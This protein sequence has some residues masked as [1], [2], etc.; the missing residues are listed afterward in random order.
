M[1]I[2]NN[3]L[4]NNMMN[5]ISTNLGRMQK[6]QNQ[7]ASGK[8][9][10]V[11]SDDPI[12]AA[13][14][15]KYRTD[16]SELGQFSR[17]LNDATSW[18]DM[19]ES[20]LGNI[21]DV[22]QR[23]RELAVQA[24]NGTNNADDTQKIAKEVDQLRTQAIHLAN[25]TYAGRYIFSGYKTDKKLINDDGTFATSVANTEAIRYEI[26]IGDS[27]DINVPGGD[28]FNNGTDAA[29]DTFSSLSG[30]NPI[31]FPVTI[32][33]G[34]NDSLGINVD[35]EAVTATIPA[36]NYSDLASLANVVQTAVNVGTLTSAD[37]NVSVVGNSL[38]FR[39]GSAGA[40]S[41]ISIVATS[42]AA[43]TLGVDAITSTPSQTGQKGKLMQD[44]DSLLTAMNTGDNATISKLIGD[45]DD[46]MNNMLRIRADVGA[47]QNRLELTGNRLENDNLNFTKLMSDN[48]DVD[49]SE[50]IMNLQNEENVYKASLAGGAKII[51]PS[52]VDFLR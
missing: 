25:S 17:N 30:N 10:Q 35:G 5:N 20:T 6:Y 39:S 19:T 12:V 2:T 7:L 45:L 1:R 33:T 15:L 29:G 42:N 3:M 27:I 9:I 46:D 23:T 8:K 44:F 48:E 28:M 11:P 40:N 43:V 47:R 38:S 21:G 18:M 22:L 24:S 26:G 4:V 31:T 32:T 49:M 16:V 41:S 50:T 34:T 36:G 51:Q 13:R 14:A 52:L 37:I